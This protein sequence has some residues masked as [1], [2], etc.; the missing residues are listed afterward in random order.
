MAEITLLGYR[1][2][3]SAVHRLDGRLK[4]AL[5]ILA[6]AAASAAGPPGLLALLAMVAAAHVAARLAP[7]PAAL[8]AIAPLAALVVVTRGLSEP[9]GPRVL[10]FSVDGLALGAVYALRLLVMAL[11]GSL[12][13]ST[14][15]TMALRASIAWVL[16]P[17][18]RRA[19]NRASTMAGLVM[20]SLPLISRELD[21]IREARAAR[22]AE[23]RRSFRERALSLARPLLRK[24][25]LRADTLA[26][27]M[28]SRCYSE[29]ARPAPL[30]GPAP[31]E[32][33]A[34]GLAACAVA[35]AAALT[36][37]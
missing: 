7:A 27:A 35:A 11:T 30:R 34:F 10:F 29:S 21:R 33:A 19:V 5:A 25:L 1:P 8:R 12:L 14:T 37:L 22:L 16:R 6:T 32:W 36:F 17:L 28:D 26:A 24:T 20:G 15:T 2:G 9:A 31:W 23:R 4:L 3:R 18:P 13:A